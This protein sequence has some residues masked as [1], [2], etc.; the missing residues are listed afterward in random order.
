MLE[1]DLAKILDSRQVLSEAH[2]KYF[3]YQVCR[4]LKFLH[5]AGILHRDLKPANLL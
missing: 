1:T 3:I 4:A 2:V 5:S